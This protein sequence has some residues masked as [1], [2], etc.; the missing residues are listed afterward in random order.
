MA[1]SYTP[2]G[3]YADVLILPGNQVQKVQVVQG[4]TIP[5]GIFFALPILPNTWKQ[6]GGTVEMS[7]TADGIQDLAGYPNVASVSYAE[8]LD[9]NGLVQNYMNATIQ[10]PTPAGRSGTF[11]TILQVPLGILGADPAIRNTVLEQ[12]IAP[13]VAQLEKTA[14]G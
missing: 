6:D 9:S 10:I 14:N 12:M 4:T 7:T 2:Q 11:E 5:Q 3:S 1:L 8:D 13:V